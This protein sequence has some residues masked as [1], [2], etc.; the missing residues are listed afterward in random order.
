[1]AIEVSREFACE[2]RIQLALYLQVSGL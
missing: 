1:M 2:E